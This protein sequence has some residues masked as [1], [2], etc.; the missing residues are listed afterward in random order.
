MAYFQ[1]DF[2]ICDLVNVF[3]KIFIIIIIF[4]FGGGG[5][6]GRGG[7]LIFRILQ[8]SFF[9]FSHL[10]VTSHLFQAP[11]GSLHYRL[12]WLTITYDC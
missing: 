8:F 2:C 7:G 10:F 12:L 9:Q 5:G 6:G 3:C 4:F 1:K 11:F